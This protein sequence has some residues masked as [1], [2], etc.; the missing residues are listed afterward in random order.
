[1]SAVQ[2]DPSP[3][4]QY[5]AGVSTPALS[6]E[7]DRR[8][9]WN[10][11][12]LIGF[13]FVFV[14][15]AIFSVPRVLVQI[16]V[17][18]PLAGLLY[19]SPLQTIGKWFGTTV[20]HVPITIAATGSGDTM[21]RWVEILV[22][23]GIAAI[24]T[25]IWSIADRKRREYRTLHEWLRVGMRFSLAFILFGY[26]FAKIWPN[27]FPQPTLERLAEPLGEFSPMGLLWTFMGYSVAYNFFTGMGEAVGALLLCFRRT[28]TLGALL[29]IAVMANV[30]YLNFAYD[31]PVKLF[32]SI[33]L[34]MA[35]FL[36]LPDAKRLSNVL[37]LNRATEPRN[38][39]LF[40][41]PKMERASMIA[42]GL[43]VAW[44]L[45]GNVSGNIGRY[46][47]STNAPLP[48][49]YGIYD[50]QSLT[51]NGKDV[52][53]VVTDPTLWH[54]VIFSRFDRFSVRTMSDSMSRYTLK[55]TAASKSFVATARFDTT[56]KLTFAF[57]KP[58][59]DQLVLRG[60][61]GA[62]SIVARLKRIDESKFLLTSRGFNWVQEQPF[63]R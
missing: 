26:G 1:M 55:M 2:L 35:I 52:P 15:F 3:S 37:L 63:N 62:D 21:I 16:P 19:Y 46:N 17:I 61:V 47:S 10:A 58:A 6:L 31:V 42:R 53:L 27:Q 40:S 34:V 30:V 8:P 51:R 60:R 24:A 13:R 39:R 12:Q 22:Q 41:T 38:L 59:P 43:L 14:F 56:Q 32:S 25:I 54:R 29:L 23:L 18:G 28:T 44:V 57:E 36:V 49:L 20:L 7:T 33:Y 48:A 5:D 11:F 9:D 50:V 4:A 45:Y